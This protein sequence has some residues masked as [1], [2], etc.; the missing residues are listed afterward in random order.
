M[1]LKHP[2]KFIYKGFYCDT[3]ILQLEVVNVTIKPALSALS[4]FRT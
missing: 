4:Q 2:Q 1:E 3:A